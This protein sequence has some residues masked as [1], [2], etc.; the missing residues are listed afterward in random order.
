MK[1]ANWN[2]NKSNQV[3]N[4]PQWIIYPSAIAPVIGRQQIKL[5]VANE[6]WSV[7]YPSELIYC[8]LHLNKTSHKEKWRYTKFMKG[9][10]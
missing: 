8:A 7:E 4:F 3:A 5:I 10:I 6:S 1:T 9:K 2:S